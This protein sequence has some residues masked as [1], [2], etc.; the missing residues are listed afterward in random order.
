MLGRQFAQYARQLSHALVRSGDAG[1]AAELLDQINSGAALGCIQHQ[2]HHALGLKRRTKRTDAGIGVAEMMKHASADDQIE[3]CLKV[4]GALDTQGS[5][6]LRESAQ[7]L[8]RRGW[9]QR[10]YCSHSS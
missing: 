4:C 2:L 10:Q 5:R 6:W 1:P 8:R 9:S 3:A 7:A